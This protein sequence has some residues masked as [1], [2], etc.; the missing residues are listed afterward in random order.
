MQPDKQD[1][2]IFYY[3]STVKKKKS[4]CDKRIINLLNIQDEEKIQLKPVEKEG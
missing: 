1:A 4:A 2:L 3:I